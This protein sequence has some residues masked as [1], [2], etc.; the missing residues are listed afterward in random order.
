MLPERELGNSPFQTHWGHRM[1][2]LGRIKSNIHAVSPTSECLIGPESLPGPVSFASLVNLPTVISPYLGCLFVRYSLF[3]FPKDGNRRT[4]TEGRAPFPEIPRLW[5]RDWNG[6]SPVLWK[7]AH[8]GPGSTPWGEPKRLESVF[9][10]RWG[11]ARTQ[12][13]PRRRSW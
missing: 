9:Q 13:K 2:V 8:R 3:Q 11:K 6:D 7:P 10:E 12:N 1:L 5:R 4:G